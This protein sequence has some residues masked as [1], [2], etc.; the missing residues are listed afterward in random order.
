MKRA[1]QWLGA[2]TAG[3][4]LAAGIAQAD[5]VN[6][7]F[8]AGDFTGWTVDGSGLWRIGTGAD[9][10][11]PAGDFGAV[12]DAVTTIE[13]PFPKFFVL[14]QELPAAPGETW[15]AS[16]WIRTVNLQG[17]N[18]SESWLELQFW[19]SGAGVLG[20]GQSAHVAANQEFTQMFVNDLV[21]PAGTVQVSVRGVVMV[22]DV[23]G[24]TEF[25]IFDD[26]QAIPEPAT[27][28]LMIIA[29]AGLLFMRRRRNL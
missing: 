28:G 26:F 21:A 24:D 12:F 13:A 23:P 16:V 11:T 22:S 8:E 2:V 9:N 7:D 15:S 10:H 6:P 18:A 5:L 27:A 17:A 29:S 19:D 14:Q 1:K 4:M 20:Q 3:L 25:H